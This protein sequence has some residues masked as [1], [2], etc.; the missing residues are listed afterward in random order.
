MEPAKPG[1]D[2]GIIDTIMRMDGAGKD[3]LYMLGGGSLHP[4][5]HETVDQKM[6]YIY[7]EGRTVYKFAVGQM[8]KVSVEILK[9][10]GITSE[11]LRLFIPH[12]ANKRIIDA[13]AS[14]LHLKP[15]QV[16]SNI[17]KYANTTAATIPIGLVEAVDDERIQQGDL[18]LLS[19]FGAGFTWGSIVLK[20][21]I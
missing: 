3:Y 1:T 21:G 6:H 14:R 4:P 15:E 13:C 19:S 5:T 2:Y 10:N 11:D 8:A 7:Q 17:D 9:K 12:Q 20:W 18:I 16:M